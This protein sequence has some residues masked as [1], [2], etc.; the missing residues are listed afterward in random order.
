MV[1]C[2]QILFCRFFSCSAVRRIIFLHYGFTPMITPSLMVT[3]GS[4]VTLSTVRI[5]CI[6]TTFLFDISVRTRWLIP[7]S[8]FIVR[9]A[10]IVVSKIFYLPSRIP[11]STYMSLI[12]E[13][14]IVEQYC[15]LLGSNREML[16]Y[17][18]IICPNKF[19][20]KQMPNF[21]VLCQMLVKI[22][23]DSEP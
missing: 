15:L 3:L 17:N 12:S 16:F 7:S 14:F 13:I 8:Q 23:A 22:Y 10:M 21:A 5:L 6:M 19:W 2:F 20:E 18:Y 11:S 4:M 9:N 1:F